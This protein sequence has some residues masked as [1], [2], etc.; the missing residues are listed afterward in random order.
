MGTFSGSLDC[1]LHRGLAVLNVSIY[2]RHVLNQE[3]PNIYSNH[4]NEIKIYNWKKMPHIQKII[5]GRKID[6]HFAH[7][8][9]LA[10]NI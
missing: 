9:F 1:P 7:I 2:T 3:L 10:W 4:S 5:E 6:T 8:T